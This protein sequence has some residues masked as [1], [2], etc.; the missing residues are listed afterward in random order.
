MNFDE[1]VWKDIIE[2]DVINWKRA[3]KF[4]E[5][6]TL[7]CDDCS[8]KKVLDIG[9]RNGGLSLYWALKGADVVCSDIEIN[10]FEKAQDLHTKYKVSDKISYVQMDVTK[11]NEHD[12]YDIITFKSVM[13]GVGYNNNFENQK[14][15]M[16]NIYRALKPGGRLYFVEN[17]K[18]S[19]IHQVSRRIF[20]TWGARWRYV[21]LAELAVLSNKYSS[22]EFNTYGFLGI[23]FRFS[24]TLNK[25]FSN[26]DTLI[27]KYIHKEYRYII[28]AVL[29]K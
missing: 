15:M 6:D 23:F 17:C 18:A 7:F 25:I 11:L 16:D 27:D 12:K 14:I 19:P 21:S 20:R 13:G 28:S 5:N 29:T 22:V 10:G 8:G 24:Y 4:W 3:I 2:W 9:G 26:L 1:D